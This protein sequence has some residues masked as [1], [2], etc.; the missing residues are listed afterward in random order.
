MNPLDDRTAEEMLPQN[1]DIITFLHHVTVSSQTASQEMQTQALAHVRSRLLEEGQLHMEEDV[2]SAIEP[3]ELMGISQ[4][5]GHYTTTLLRK[6]SA[7]QQRLGLLV[8][9]LCVALLV[10]SFVTIEQL[11]HHRN[12]TI[13]SQPTKRAISTSTVRYAHFKVVFVHMQRT[14]FKPSFVEIHKG[15]SI[16]FI[17]DTPTEHDLRNG[18]WIDRN[19]IRVST[20]QLGAPPEPFIMYAYQQLQAINPFTTVGTY[21]LYDTLHS[22]MNLTIVVKK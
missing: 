3:V 7:W 13:S 15:M 8:A 4:E 12:T 6:R 16:A 21:Y 17:N 5:K 9:V 11:S 20:N 19:T 14:S 10:S 2:H 22:G 1:K 18:R